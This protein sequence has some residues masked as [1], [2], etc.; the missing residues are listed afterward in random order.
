[1]SR[2]QPKF[3]TPVILEV[4]AS[5]VASA[6]AAQE[7]GA[8][9]VE[10]CENLNE[11]GT[12]P[13]HGQISLARQLL[14]IK[15]YVLI[16]P[17]GGD[18]LYS[19]LEFDIMVA[20]IKY[21]IAAGCDGVVI[22]ILNPDGTIDKKRC[23]ILI[24]LAKQNGLGVTFH[25]AIDMCADIFQGMEDIIDL[26]CERLLTSGGKSTAIEG[27]RIIGELVKKAAG[28]ISIMPGSGVNENNAADLV[29]YTKVSEIHSSAR[30]HLQ[31]KMTYKNDHI[32]MRDS[33]GDEYKIG[34]TDAGKVQQIIKAINF[35]FK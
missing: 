9:R 20:D 12:T 13:S 7:G 18:F 17:R 19:D 26:G 24:N 34:V 3:K 14:A 33:Y 30:V 5:S 22:G 23:S 28:R 15:L 2:E 11:G 31:S 29:F 21:C 32:L 4:C 35:D 10:L 8:F 27:S 25:R 6:L 16:R 1:M